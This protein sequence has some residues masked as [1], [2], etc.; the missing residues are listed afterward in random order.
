MDRLISYVVGIGIPLIFYFIIVKTSNSIGLG[1]ITSSLNKIGF[2]KGIHLGIFI[3]NFIAILSFDTIKMIY[4][5]YY[6]YKIRV[7][8]KATDLYNKEKIKNR[9]NSYFIS[10]DLKQIITQTLF[11]I[12]ED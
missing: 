10:K 7:E 11:R 1:A 8:I 9:I 6:L 4:K 3:L 5:K 2:G 12:D